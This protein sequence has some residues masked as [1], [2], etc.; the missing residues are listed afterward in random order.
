MKAIVLY[1]HT[2]SLIKINEIIKILDHKVQFHYLNYKKDLSSI[3]KFLNFIKKK[4]PNFIIDLLL[5]PDTEL[6]NETYKKLIKKIY[7]IR[8]VIKSNNIK[9]VK[10]SHSWLGSNDVFPYKYFLFLRNLFFYFKNFFL[11]DFYKYHRTSVT[12]LTSKNCENNEKFFR[13]NKIYFKHYDYFSKDRKKKINKRLVYIDQF[14]YG[15]PDLVMN[16]VNLFNKNKFSTEIKNFFSLLEK[17]GYKI[18]IALHPSNASKIYRSI[19]GKRNFVK[20][21][22]SDIIIGSSGVV[23]HD[24]M[25]INFAVQAKKPIIFITTD[26]LQTSRFGKRINTHAKFF[27]SAL[28]NISKMKINKIHLPK[29]KKEIYLNYEKKFL[30]HEK[31]QSQKKFKLEFIKSIS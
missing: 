2:N 19:Y 26:E 10:I 31:F 5:T 22:T 14:L 1:H 29:I 28:I 25:A 8:N 4:K 24:S 12:I 7:K 17:D 11:E 23:A 27:N 20:G 18:D 30:K 15:H 13:T 3:N 16:G 6:R 9:T 21:K